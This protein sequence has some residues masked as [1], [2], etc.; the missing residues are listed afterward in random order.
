M[1]STSDIKKGLC[2]KL[3]SDIYKVIEFL[4]VK[5]GK[6]PAFLRTKIKPLILALDPEDDLMD[7]SA[8]LEKITPSFEQYRKD[9]QEY[10]DSCK[11]SDSPAI[12][13]ANPVVILY[14]GV[15]MFTFAKNK[16]TAR[17]ASEFYIN[18]VNVM[19]G[20]E[21]ISKYT[22]LPRQEAFDIEYW[23]LEEAKLQRLS[24][25]HI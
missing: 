6:G 22:S 2:I 14:P 11:R 19:R 3:N 20:A 9:Y 7:A 16:Q 10:Y 4:H 12:R 25:I 13:D 17:V 23:L 24:L 8:V 21:A 1:A 18:A 15:G 5:P